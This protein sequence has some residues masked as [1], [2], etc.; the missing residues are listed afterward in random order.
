MPEGKLGIFA[1]LGEFCREAAVLIF[2]FGD[3]DD[4]LHDRYILLNIIKV[5][6]AALI[7][8]VTGIFFEKWRKP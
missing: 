2:V 8:L 7:F 3:L 4:W 1:M 5:F 6:G